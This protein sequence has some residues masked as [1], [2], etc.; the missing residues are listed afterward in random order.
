MT[1][2]L[3]VETPR[4]SV[5][6]WVWHSLVCQGSLLKEYEYVCVCVYHREYDVKKMSAAM[7][8]VKYYLQIYNTKHNVVDSVTGCKIR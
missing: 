1:R 4:L 5:K 2:Q 3:L 7:I 6:V 8:I